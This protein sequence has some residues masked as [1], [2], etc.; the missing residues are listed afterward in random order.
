MLLCLFVAYVKLGILVLNIIFTAHFS[1]KQASCSHNFIIVEKL[2]FLL[3]LKLFFFSTGTLDT[4]V[5]CVEIIY[6]TLETVGIYSSL[7]TSSHFNINQS[8]YYLV[9]IYNEKIIIK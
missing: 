4:I 5:K 7:I 1:C 8:I 3:C 9:T 2:S 6:E